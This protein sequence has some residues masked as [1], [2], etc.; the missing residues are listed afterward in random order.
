MESPQFK[1]L[2]WENETNIGESTEATLYL[3]KLQ[4]FFI[5]PN[6]R[7]YYIVK[8]VKKK[9]KKNVITTT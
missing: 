8:D 1:V 6:R 3:C 9:K 5:C 2:S 4:M 7:I